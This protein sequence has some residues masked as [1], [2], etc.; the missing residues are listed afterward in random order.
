[1]TRHGQPPEG[2]GSEA[3]HRH[4]ATHSWLHAQ[5][6]CATSCHHPPPAPEARGSRTASWEPPCSGP[7]GP[8]GADVCGTKREPRAPTQHRTNRDPAAAHQLSSAAPKVTSDVATSQ[9]LANRAASPLAGA[10]GSRGPISLS[11]HQTAAQGCTGPGRRQSW[12]SHPWPGATPALRALLMGTRGPTVPGPWPSRLSGGSAPSPARP[13]PG[14]V[15]V[16]S[17]PGQAQ[18]APTAPSTW[19]NLVPTVQTGASYTASELTASLG[20]SGGRPHSLGDGPC[21][22]VREPRPSRALPAAPAT[23]RRTETGRAHGERPPAPHL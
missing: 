20:K 12:G 14:G 9:G 17:Q 2:T 8:A 22:P 11:G 23:V 4:P 13:S 1:M 21:P 18:S 6:R 10:R 5:P 3:P 16:E 15:S 19:F 7:R